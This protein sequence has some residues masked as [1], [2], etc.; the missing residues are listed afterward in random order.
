MTLQEN[1]NEQFFCVN[2]VAENIPFSKLNNNEFIISVKKGVI[3]S[4]EKDIDFVPSDFQQK[5]FDKRNS[6]INNNAFDLITE[7]EDDE[8]IPT[9]D[10]NESG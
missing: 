5:I 7:N 4:C 8:V 2:C 3:N 9:I 10:C 6:A 1:I